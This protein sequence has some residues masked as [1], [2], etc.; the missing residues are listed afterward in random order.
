MINLNGKSAS[1]VAS[2]LD[3]GRTLK[4]NSFV[5]SIRKGL[6]DADK[7]FTMNTEQLKKRLLK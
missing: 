5:E 1:A 2:F 3:D 6:A 4:K 7:G